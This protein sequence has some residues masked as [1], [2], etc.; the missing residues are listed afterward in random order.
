MEMIKHEVT[1]TANELDEETRERMWTDSPVQYQA[2][3]AYPFPAGVKGYPLGRN[4]RS[5]KGAILDLVSR[6]HMESGIRI[7]PIINK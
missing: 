3:L 4:F 6:V 1:V 7:D 5:E 2:E